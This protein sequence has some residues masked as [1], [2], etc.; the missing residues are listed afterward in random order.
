MNYDLRKYTRDRV[1]DELLAYLSEHPRATARSICKHTLWA[2][3][4][5]TGLA[6]QSDDI[7]IVAMRVGRD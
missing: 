3:R 4:R 7:T 5:Y 1:R 2:V 6:E